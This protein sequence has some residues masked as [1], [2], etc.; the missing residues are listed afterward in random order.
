MDLCEAHLDL[1]ILAIL[2]VMKLK[3][4]FVFVVI[5]RN[6]LKFFDVIN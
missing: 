4:Y 6:S 3:I 1:Y 5:M 2:Y